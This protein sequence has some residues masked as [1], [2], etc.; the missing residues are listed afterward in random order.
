M[1]PYLAFGASLL[2]VMVLVIA[3]TKIGIPAA[4]R[5][6][7]AAFWPVFGALYW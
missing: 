6:L 7:L 5:A 3:D 4:Q 1:L 2:A